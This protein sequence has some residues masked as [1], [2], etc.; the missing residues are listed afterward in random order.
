ML[1]VQKYGGT[2][3]GDVDRIQ[4]AAQRIAALAHQGT[5]VVVVCPRRGIRLMI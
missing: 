1:I 3:L 5:Q 2:S 4:T